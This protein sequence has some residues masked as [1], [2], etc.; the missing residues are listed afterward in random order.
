MFK[1][2]NWIKKNRIVTEVVCLFFLPPCFPFKRNYFS[3]KKPKTFIY[4][5]FRRAKPE[6]REV[7]YDLHFFFY[8]VTKS[9]HKVVGVSPPGSNRSCE[10]GS[11]PWGRDLHIGP[12]CSQRNYRNWYWGEIIKINL[13]WEVITRTAHMTQVENYKK[14]TAKNIL[15]YSLCITC[16][17]CEMFGSLAIKK[18]W[19]KEKI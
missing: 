4:F 6:T 18:T 9:R 2:W 10:T 3:L 7:T 1:S 14:F 11:Q 12:K 8:S 5:Y 17:K 16:R 15:H 13:W 19:N